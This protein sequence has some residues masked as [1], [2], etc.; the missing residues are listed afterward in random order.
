MEV[1]YTILV[2][3]TKAVEYTI[4]VVPDWVSCS[5]N[6][7]RIHSSAACKEPVLALV[8]E[9]VLVL[10]QVRVPDSKNRKFGLQLR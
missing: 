8:R 10:G 4:L 6:N 5:R 7:Y 1:E 2:G 3:C 9:L